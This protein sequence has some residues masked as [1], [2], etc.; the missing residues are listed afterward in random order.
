VRAI[1]AL[2]EPTC[3]ESNSGSANATPTAL[4]FAMIKFLYQFQKGEKCPAEAGL[5]A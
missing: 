1:G 2:D 4:V 3:T 5:D